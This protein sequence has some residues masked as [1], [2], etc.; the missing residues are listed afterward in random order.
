MNIFTEES[1]SEKKTGSIKINTITITLYSYKSDIKVIQEFV[2]SIKD[3]YLSHIEKKRNNKKFIYTL[4]K[5][6]H[7]ESKYECWN[8]YPF[9]STRTFDNMFFTGKT[10]IIAK[11]NYFMNNKDWYYANGIPYTLGIGLHGPPG[12]GKTSFFKCL[13]N[14]TERHLVILSLKMITTK[15]QLET[16]FFEDKY[17]VDNKN[18]SVG[19]IRKL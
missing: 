10:D 18:H 8:E 3:E 15:Q 4:T 16:F 13:A 6:T 1:D 5:T 12:T 17:N 2:E 9:E 19:L 11:I 7:D 14:M